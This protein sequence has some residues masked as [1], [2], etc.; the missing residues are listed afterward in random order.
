MGKAKPSALYRSFPQRK[1][2][3][4]KGS[5]HDVKRFTLNYAHFSGVVRFFAFRTVFARLLLPEG[6]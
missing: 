5:F 2:S 3:R 6:V 4:G 1:F